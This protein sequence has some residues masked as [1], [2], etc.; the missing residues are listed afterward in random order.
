MDL[1]QSLS[2]DT[3][4]NSYCVKVTEI[5]GLCFFF[6]LEIIPPPL[7]ALRTVGYLNAVLLIINFQLLQL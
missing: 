6:Y 7:A 1:A 4:T 5:T 2:G 3:R